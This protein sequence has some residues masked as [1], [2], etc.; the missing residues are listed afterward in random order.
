MTTGIHG[1]IVAGG[2]SVL[3]GLGVADDAALTPFAGKYRFIDFALA[4]LANGDVERI[5]VAAP[6]RGTLIRAHVAA[7]A[8]NVPALRGALPARLPGTF[9]GSRLDRIL[10]ALLGCRRLE[11]P[12]VTVVLTA[13]H[14]VQLDV[15]RLV[16][17]HRRL[18]ADVTLCTVPVAAS[19]VG[20]RIAVDVGPAG[21]VRGFAAAQG[22][23]VAVWTGDVVV[24]AAALGV[25]SAAAAGLRRNVGGR[26]GALARQLTI[27]A[28]DVDG[29]WHDPTS[30]EAYY[31]AQMNLC[32]PRPR[33][34]LYDR[35][36]PVRPVGG[37]YGPAKVVADAAGRPG[38]ALNSLVSSGAVV[39]GGAV[40]NTIL[41]HGVIVDSGAE[42]EDA[43]LLDGCRVGRMARVRRAVVGVGAV[44]GDA[45]EIGFGRPPAPP[46]R[47]LASG[48]T[49]VPPAVARPLVA[50][51][52]AR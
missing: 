8:R 9:A 20:S 4:S 46:T 39:H 51:A 35:T 13:D 19:E 37:P 50:V 41:G 5:D 29:F 49:I 25:L 23:L 1:M 12:D 44:I 43:V 10:G 42:V 15:R 18:G 31:E 45:G 14:I 2:D 48:L 27:A 36:W 40:I 33:L 30:I 47:V 34:D 3:A 22:G 28:A 24:S 32:T 52:G 11:S 38:Q 17:T 21:R 26:L 16:D 7:A 6:A